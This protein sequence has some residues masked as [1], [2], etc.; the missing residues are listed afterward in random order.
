MKTLLTT[1]MILVM[2]P[3]LAAQIQTYKLDAIDLIQQVDQLQPK[4]SVAEHFI[5][6]VQM[7]AQC[8]TTNMK[9]YLQQGIRLLANRMQEND[10]ISIVGYGDLNGVLLQQASPSVALAEIESL[11]LPARLSQLLDTSGVNTA[12]DLAT[13]DQNSASETHLLLVSYDYPQ[14]VT[15]NNSITTRN[16]QSLH[17]QS[18]HV[19]TAPAAQRE[20]SNTGAAI[21]LTAISVL[22]EVIRIIKD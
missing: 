2:L 16:V 13:L 18:Q 8:A 17:T 7:N 4:E 10:Q 9:F 15:Q 19:N 21:L 1:V 11:L 22:P 3:Q 5:L 20:G 12:Y 14:V 6:T